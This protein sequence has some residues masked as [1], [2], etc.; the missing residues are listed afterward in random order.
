MNNVRYSGPLSAAPQGEQPLPGHGGDRP[1]QRD[2]P[3]SVYSND[4][5]LDWAD[6]AGGGADPGR[7]A[8]RAGCPHG[9]VAGGM[10]PGQLPGETPEQRQARWA[11]LL[12]R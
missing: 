9:R 1:G 12:A 3:Q 10:L 4:R 2:G 6:P 11:A 8:G 7:G 5:Y